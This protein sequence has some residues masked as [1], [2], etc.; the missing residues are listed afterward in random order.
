M[1]LEAVHTSLLFRWRQRLFSLYVP[2][3]MNATCAG[4]YTLVVPFEVHRLGG[5]ATATGGVGAVWTGC[6]VLSLLIFGGRVDRFNPRTLVQMGLSVIATMILIIGVA[7]NLTVLFLASAGYGI[8]SGLFW[9]P[10]MGWISVGYEGPS[11]NRRLSIFNVSWAA[12]LVFGQP[13]G[14]ALYE[15]ARMLP[16]Y[17]AAACLIVGIAVVS[18]IRSPGGQALPTTPDESDGDV[19]AARN[20]VFRP[21]ARI[22]HF[23]SYVATGM[24]RYQLPS[25]AIALGI[26]ANVFGRVGMALSVAM[27]I[28]FYVLG[29][30]HRWHYRLGLFFGAQVVLALTVLALLSVVNWW[31]MAACMIVGGAC[32]GVTYSSDL[33]YGVS[34]GVRRGRRMAIHELILSSGMVVGAFG[35]GWVTEHVALR[36]AYPICAALLI[37]GIVVQ[38]AILVGRRPRR[39]VDGENPG[40]Q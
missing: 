25:L 32:I 10:I 19:D 22:A 33:F 15:Y 24:F 26:G 2:V 40:Y 16:F 3:L 38:L 7:P 9:P 17:V 5:G 37:L 1:A 20:D 34:G 14:G 28:S 11:L 29:R 6:Y 39:D 8:I 36:G 30:S 21:M 13:L 35:S 18:V 4:I 23:L 27:A 31:Q 12:G